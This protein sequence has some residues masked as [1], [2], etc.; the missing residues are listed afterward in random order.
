MCDPVP[1]AK[2]LNPRK[3]ATPVSSANHYAYDEH[4]KRIKK[5][6]FVPPSSSASRRY[7]NSESETD[8]EYRRQGRSSRSGYNSSSKAGFVNK[9]PAASPVRK[10]ST[11]GA[12]P[13]GAPTDYTVPDKP[14]DRRTCPV[15]WDIKKEEG[16]SLPLA[17]TFSGSVA[18]FAAN[19]APVS[20]QKAA[21]ANASTFKPTVCTVP[22]TAITAI[23][24][25]HSRREMIDSDVAYHAASLSAADGNI[26]PLELRISAGNNP[27]PFPVGIVS[28][29]EAFNNMIVPSQSGAGFTLPPDS[30]DMASIFK[31]GRCCAVL[32]PGSNGETVVDVRHAVNVDGILKATTYK[33]VDPKKFVQKSAGSDYVL[34][35]HGS[36]VHQTLVNETDAGKLPPIDFGNTVD[37]SNGQGIWIKGVPSSSASYAEKII[38]KTKKIPLGKMDINKVEFHLVPLNHTRSWKDHHLSAFDG[39]AITSGSAYNAM[40]APVTVSCTMCIKHL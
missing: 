13:S 4:G 1:E 40:S 30:G 10:P 15:D 33:D 31:R 8:R 34:V 36:C 17:I 23:A 25:D 35:K 28:S 2:A 19:K 6:N 5:N 37:L 22:A 24:H 27:L 21:N 11:F 39:T 3:S 18:Q 38:T 12:P 26:I 9:T 32:Q 20:Q 7:V 29:H 14:F 16:L